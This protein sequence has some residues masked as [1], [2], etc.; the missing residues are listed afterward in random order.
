MIKMMI[1]II[2]LSSDL[3]VRKKWSPCHP[4]ACDKSVCPS[5]MLYPPNLVYNGY[6][7]RTPLLFKAPE[8]KETSTKLGAK[9]Q[10][11]QNHSMFVITQIKKTK[12]FSLR[13]NT[14]PRDLVT[15][16]ELPRSRWQ[17][18]P[19]KPGLGVS[20]APG[21]F[22]DHCPQPRSDDIPQL[23]TVKDSAPSPRNAPVLLRHKDRVLEGLAH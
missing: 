18:W 5:R 11:R 13:E 20:G 4:S 23:I 6:S 19:R 7:T 2:S 16:P 21:P 14:R 15:V 12:S 10:E 8:L 22:Q 17:S 3:R 1:I 9:R